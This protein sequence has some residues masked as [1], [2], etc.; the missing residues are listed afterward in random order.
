MREMKDSGVE[1]IG[2]IPNGWEISRVS[3]FFDIQ[4]G[5]MLQ[6]T[7]DKE[8]ETLEEYLCS[9]NVSNNEITQS[10]LK[11]MWF[12][13]K[14]KQ[15]YS[16]KQ[17][18]LIVV[19]GGDVAASAIVKTLVENLYFQNA[20]H[21]VRS[22]ASFDVRYLHYL[23]ITAKASGQIDLLCNKA[24]ISHFS[25]EKFKALEF[26]VNS[27]KEQ[28][29]I[30]DYL[31]AKC[32]QIDRAI[33]RQQEVIDKLKE[34]KLSVI[35]EAVTKG[36]N[37]D[38]PMKES[39]IEWIG[40]IPEGWK[41]IRVKWLLVER[42]DRSNDGLEEPLSM[43]QKFGLIPTSEMEMVP[44]MASSFIG[45]K[46]V[47]E[48]DLVFNKLKAHLGVFSVSKYQGLVSPDYAVYYASG[49]ADL[50]YLEYLFKTP[51]CILEFRKNSSG[52]ADGLTRLYTD[53]LYSIECPLPDKEEQL[54][55]AR[56][57]NEKCACIEATI[58]R[59]QDVIGK[60][61]EYKKSL[62]YE[63]VTGKREV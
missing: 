36:L 57:L 45:A 52:I 24:T 38:V 39:G 14:E 41:T 17:G 29:R 8:D 53:G 34:Y 51:Q 3:Y 5:K 42:K 50:K 32:T 60:L 49:R 22:S 55:I 63:V 27:S 56:V 21:R 12:S 20:L 47:Y 6:P 26:I 35:T 62:I 11:T 40:K 28:H 23:L 37:H 10:D 16:I 31:D 59:K 43:S 44:N 7:Q 30:A 33:A 58:L 46:L 9:I 13:P 61:T 19:E 2:E 54:E 48:N 4:L 15:N 25:K 18:D 1:W